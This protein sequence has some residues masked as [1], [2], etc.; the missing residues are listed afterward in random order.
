MVM[1]MY[2]I[3][4]YTGRSYEKLYKILIWGSLAL[5]PVYTLFVVTGYQPITWIVNPT[6][7]SNYSIM[8]YLVY[9]GLTNLM[10]YR[11]TRSYVYSFTLSII[12][13]ASIGY[14]YEV[15]LWLERGGVFEL[16]RTAKNSFIVLD[17]GM[18]AVFFMIYMVYEKRPKLNKALI[19]SV[20]LYVG[21]YLFYFRYYPEFFIRIY[22]Y[23]KIPT[24]FLLRLPAMYMV[25]QFINSPPNHYFTFLHYHEVSPTQFRKHVEYLKKHYTVT[26]L[27]R[28][29]DHYTRGTSLPDNPLFICFDDGWA[30]NYDLLSVIK[31]TGTPVT[32]FLATGY[33]DTRLNPRTNTEDPRYRMLS[34]EQVREM[35]PF[36]CFQS[37]GVSHRRFTEINKLQAMNE[38]H[39]S[40]E[41]IEDL[42]GKQVY[43]FAYPYNQPAYNEELTQTGYTFARVGE[44]SLNIDTPEIITS[45]GIK[46]EWSIN[47]LRHTLLKAA[48][49]THLLE[50]GAYRLPATQDQS[51]QLT[52]DISQALATDM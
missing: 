8:Q 40:K 2:L 29:R 22:P 46:P 37:H 35:D 52:R 4:K 48:I 26:H 31:E 51:H 38:Y 50:K 15:P 13:A 43:A 30:S 5:I 36:V 3:Q 42:T 34:E 49:K 39:T 21:Y 23:T 6:W 41:Y 7:T 33:I 11:R 24:T 20:F 45:I 25:I 19:I 18:L 12:S 32:I 27:D 9:L 10:L 1:G 28:L 44:R 47:A 14:L 17:F 16:I